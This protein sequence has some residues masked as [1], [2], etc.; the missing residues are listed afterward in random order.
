MKRANLFEMSF[1]E[2]F[3]DLTAPGL[4]SIQSFTGRNQGEVQHSTR[5]MTKDPR[6]FKSVIDS[7]STVEETK[8][9][10]SERSSMKGGV[11]PLAQDD[12]FFLKNY[13]S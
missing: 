4:H 11:R 6:K 9:N 10:D 3:D 5:Q 2:K 7:F 13:E 8:E 1:T 12:A